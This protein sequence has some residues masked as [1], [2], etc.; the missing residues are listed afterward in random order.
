MMQGVSTKGRIALACAIVAT[1][2]AVFTASASAQTTTYTTTQTGSKSGGSKKAPAPFSGSWVLKGDAGPGL[3]PASPI[4]WSWGWEGVVVKPKG[5]PVCT[6]EQIDA[7][8]SNSVCPKGSLI[9]TSTP[10]VAQF[11]PAGDKTQNASC[12]GKSF[13]FYNAGPGKMVLYIDGPGEQCGG[14]QYFPPA[15]MTVTTKNNSSTMGLVW[16]ANIPNPLPGLK[17]A[18]NEGGGIFPVTKTTVKKK[19]KKVKSAYFQS[20]GCSGTRD[21]TFTVVDEEIGTT[22]LKGSAGK[23]TTPKKKKKK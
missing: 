16:P 10:L 4:S 6:P 19:G 7:A 23:C 12:A 17:G 8:Q 3:R 9:G 21:F 2:S 18:L 13:L 20:V 11:G 15:A 1:A 14:L 22:T 5:F